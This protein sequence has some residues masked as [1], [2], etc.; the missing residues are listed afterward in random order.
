MD[1]HA[2]QWKSKS[3]NYFIVLS[4]HWLPIPKGRPAGLAVN[5]LGDGH[6]PFTLIFIWNDEVGTEEKPRKIPDL[7]KLTPKGRVSPCKGTPG[8]KF[9]GEKFWTFKTRNQR[10][11]LSK[12]KGG[13]GG[14]GFDS[15]FVLSG[16]SPGLGMIPLI[17]QSHQS[18]RGL[19]CISCPEMWR[20]MTFAAALRPPVHSWRE[21]VSAFTFGS[22]PAL[23]SKLR[24]FVCRLLREFLLLVVLIF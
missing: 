2:T 10:T 3:K 7:Q 21:D 9:L 11:S 4:G 17:L 23:C 19:N 6:A 22:H 15:L 14:R 1:K 20:R 18:P 5:P 12:R 16:E 13:R 24:F 8:D